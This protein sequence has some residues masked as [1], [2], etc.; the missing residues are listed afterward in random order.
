MNQRL[1]KSNNF[2][3]SLLTE[4]DFHM[5]HGQLNQSLIRIRLRLKNKIENNQLE[6]VRFIH[7]R[8]IKWI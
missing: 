4:P 6:N 3:N 1:V 7:G 8:I 2:V 5:N